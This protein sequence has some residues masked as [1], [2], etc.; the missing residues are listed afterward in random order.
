MSGSS[1]DLKKE[2]FEKARIDYHSLFIMLWLSCNSWYNF[3]YSLTN[4]REHI[5]KIKS[6]RSSNNK[7][8]QSF[9]RLFLSDDKEGA[10]FRNNI[11]QLHYALIQAELEYRGNDIPNGY[12]KMIFENLLTDF[13][14]KTDNTSYQ[15]VIISDARTKTG[16]LKKKYS[17]T[18]D[19]GDLVVVED[20]GILFAGIFE[21]IYQVRCHLVHGSLKPSKENHAVVRCCYLILWDCLKGFCE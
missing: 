5:N 6:D 15:N 16:K 18:H 3:H 13:N 19:L 11:T 8:Y 1:Q 2:W 4:D 14:K 20:L 12:T 21:I 10:D 9:E 17:D 7:L